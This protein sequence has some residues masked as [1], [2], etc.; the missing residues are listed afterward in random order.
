M[1]TDAV[2]SLEDL[3]LKT[4]VKG[5]LRP[6]EVLLEIVQL[7]LVIAPNE[8]TYRASWDACGYGRSDGTYRIS[9]GMSLHTGT[10]KSQR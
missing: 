1:L 6:L 5:L 7:L 8:I 4:E 9:L 3:Q 10:H 2:D